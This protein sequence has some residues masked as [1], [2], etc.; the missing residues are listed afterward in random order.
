MHKT[1][2]SVP[3]PTP[4]QVDYAR[5]ISRQLN[6]TIPWQDIQDRQALSNWIGAHQGAFKKATYLRQKTYGATSRQVAYA[7]RIAQRK[8]M[9]VPVECFRD[10]GLMSRWI[11]RNR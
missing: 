11:D 7:E 4:S 6:E 5:K 1:Q 2:P 8:R 10:A 3:G 9:E